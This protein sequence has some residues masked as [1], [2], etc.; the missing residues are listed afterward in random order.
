MWGETGDDNYYRVA[1][2]PSKNPMNPIFVLDF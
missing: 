2:K 1:T